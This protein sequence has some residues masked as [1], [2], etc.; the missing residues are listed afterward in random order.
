MSHH[1]PKEWSL[2]YYRDTPEPTDV[3]V[4]EEEDD[5][6]IEID[7]PVPI[8]DPSTEIRT[9]FNLQSGITLDAIM[10]GT[11]EPTLENL[12]NCVMI[13]KTQS[14][15]FIVS[16]VNNEFL[17]SNRSYTEWTKEYQKIDK[18]IADLV[19]QLP[20]TTCFD[21]KLGMLQGFDTTKAKPNFDISPIY[22][23]IRNGLCASNDTYYN[24]LL[25]Y[26]AHMFQRPF[27]R[28]DITILML[29]LQGTGK[30]TFYKLLQACLGIFAHME[31]NFKEFVSYSKKLMAST[32]LLV[33]VDEC[34]KLSNDQLQDL[35]NLSTSKQSLFK[36]KAK[37][38]PFPIPIYYRIFLFSNDPNVIQTD[39]SDRRW[40]YLK[41]SKKN[42]NR[43]D[44]LYQFLNDPL[45]GQVKPD[46][47]YKFTL[48]MMTRDISKF[49]P[50]HSLV[51]E[52][53]KTLIRSQMK[54]DDGYVYDF[55]VINEQWL[56]SWRTNQLVFEEY[57]NYIADQKIKNANLDHAF[58]GLQF[59]KHCD[60]KERKLSGKQKKEYQLQE[61]FKAYK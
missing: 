22:D 58:L 47:A 44:N 52:T 56:R 51:T 19:D 30:G 49:N 14:I 23:M 45:T 21:L 48:D 61:G 41:G 37:C 16:N 17:V 36:I 24:F 20:S 10:N 27:D 25:D 50:H 1:F 38:E 54:S 32:K 28:P 15:I 33:C 3:I 6:V 13:N 55:C 40:F 43:F 9:C 46:I 31:P 57:K 4:V 12:S 39:P 53:H 7:P 35:K 11:I 59:L 60:T 26:V 34:G 2:E 5:D 42:A 18:R 8:V 29:G